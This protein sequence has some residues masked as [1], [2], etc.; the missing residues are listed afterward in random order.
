MLPETK[1]KLKQE[2]EV[3]LSKFPNA[4]IKDLRE[5][6]RTESIAPLIA[7][8]KKTSFS[9][10]LKDNINK[11]RETGSCLKHKGTGNNRTKPTVE[12]RIKRLIFNEEK[13]S[14]R[15]VAALTGVSKTTVANILHRNGGIAY[16]KYG[17]QKLT[18]E[19]KVRRVEFCHYLLQ[20]F[21]TNPREGRSWFRIINTDF[22]VNS[23]SSNKKL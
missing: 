12:A 20:K 17:C 6:L 2:I 14:L 19:H 10:C 7:P 4:D 16:K 22:S 18:E 15:T 3:Y 5:F 8:F 13:R 1:K 9:I 23:N 21:G 11:F